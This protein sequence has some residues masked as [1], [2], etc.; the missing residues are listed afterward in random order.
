MWWGIWVI[1]HWYSPIECV[2][3]DGIY[4]YVPMH[5]VKERGSISKICNNMWQNIRIV[6]TWKAKR[7]ATRDIVM[8]SFPLLLS[9]LCFKGQ[10]VWTT[11]DK[12]RAD[13]WQR[14]GLIC[15]ST[16]EIGCAASGGVVLVVGLPFRCV[17][18]GKCFVH[19][20]S[21]MPSTEEDSV[22]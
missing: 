11:T 17:I 21:D 9:F 10:V 14:N 3:N 6:A 5:L 22:E 20:D 13:C 7:M 16:K 8:R 4:D 2:Y 12:Q 1:L 19:E 15:E 18:D